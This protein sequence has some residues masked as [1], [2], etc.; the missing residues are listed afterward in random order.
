MLEHYVIV[1]NDGIHKNVLIITPP[2]CF[3][4]ENAHR[5]I[6]ALDKVLQEIE[7]MTI[8]EEEDDVPIQSYDK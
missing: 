6:V 2:M 8:E 4:C 3:T 1:A 7:C 5:F